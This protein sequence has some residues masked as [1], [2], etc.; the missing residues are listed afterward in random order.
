M[1]GAPSAITT[2]LKLDR[3]YASIALDP[4]S[5]D[6]TEGS[7]LLSWLVFI[8]SAA[9]AAG[10][11][12]FAW[13]QPLIAG[14]VLLGLLA[15]ALGRWISR[16]RLLRVLRS[17]DVD[18]VLKNW[19]PRFDRIPHP[20]TMAPL[21]TAT[22]FAAYGWVDKARAAIA[23]AERGPAWEAAIE[24][25]LFLDALLLTFEG[26]RDS[27]L[28]QAGRL[29]RLPL[30]EAAPVLRDRVVLLRKAMAALARAFAHQTEPGDRQIL[31]QASESAPVVFFWAL[32][33]ASAVLAIDQ[34]EPRRAREL[35]EGAPNW[36]REST[37]RAFHDEIVAHAAA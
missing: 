15:L 20:A 23:A 26:E 29:E 17:G 8:A 16:R 7:R 22:I 34:G 3:P 28:E 1:K 18:S 5:T 30:P 32:R 12:R 21:M 36:P 9:L 14:F 13:Y 27:A 4:F 6:E 10:A 19:S 24:H 25:R 31:E 11:L 2:C 37:F 33:Y 35:L